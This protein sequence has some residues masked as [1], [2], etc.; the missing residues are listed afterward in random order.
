[1]PRSISRR[2]VYA[3][4]PLL[5]LFLLGECAGRLLEKTTNYTPRR[6]AGF[7]QQSPYVRGALVPGASFRSG[8]MQITVDE[9]G[10]RGDGVT[11]TK[12]PGVF[13]IV[14]L[15]G[16]STFGWK[17]IPGHGQAWPALLETELQARTGRAVEVIN[18]GVPGWSSVESRVSLLL[19]VQRL[20]PDAV[21]LYHGNNDIDWSHRPGVGDGPMYARDL[22]D[23]SHGFFDRLLDTSYVLMELRSRW[24]FL[25]RSRGTHDDVDPAALSMLRWNLEEVITDARARG[26][27]LAVGSY[28]NAVDETA[29]A[30]EFSD[31]ERA[32][33]IPSM[34]RWFAHLSVQGARA[35]F[36]AHRGMVQDVAKDEEVLF[37]DIHGAVPPNT[38][39][40][41][42]WCHLT[43]EGHKR[44]AQTWAETIVAAGWV[45]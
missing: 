33:G 13:R 36:A 21:L 17:G 19:R 25:N 39:H 29:A 20:D 27:H 34:G 28:A 7:V 32:L 37:V 23:S 35:S 15:G 41:V 14:A 2:V 9:L 11:P 38:N 45:R 40:F 22:L 31:D 24:L 18:A 16:S 12:P 42:D 10:F 26:L 1:V 44:V 6:R 30:G 8:E 5:A 3:C 4:L 43:P